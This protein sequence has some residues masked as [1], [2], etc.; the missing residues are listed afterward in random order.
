M[1]DNNSLEMKIKGKM[2]HQKVAAIQ[3]HLASLNLQEAP[4]IG[5]FT[6]KKGDTVLAQFS[7]DN[8]WNR[9][10]IVNAPKGGADSS[11]DKFEV[12][13]IDYGNQEVVTQS[14]L[15]P[16][17]PSVSSLP[18]LA[19]LCSLAYLK[20]PNMFMMA[21]FIGYG[22]NKWLPK[23]RLHRKRTKDPYFF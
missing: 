23:R 3:N 2:L 15:R 5:A 11:G 14:Q 17:D 22:E 4:S 12:F 1:R 7:A 6:P 9:A 16:I 10:L 8:S 20:V 21:N 13:Y 18:G 19:Q